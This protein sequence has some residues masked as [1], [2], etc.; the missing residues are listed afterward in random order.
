LAHPDPASEPTLDGSQIW[1]V[2]L[3]R[4]RLIAAIVLA[5]LLLA[6]IQ[7]VA[8]AP[9][10]D[11]KSSQAPTSY[12]ST[13]SYMAVTTSVEGISTEEAVRVGQSLAPT[14][15]TLMRGPSVMT[16]LTAMTG[17]EI[18]SAA[19]SFSITVPPDTALIWVTSSAPDERTAIALAN[20]MASAMATLPGLGEINVG[21]VATRLELV[22]AATSATPV[23]APTRSINTFVLFISV[24]MFLGVLTAFVVEWVDGRAN[25]PGQVESETGM[26]AIGRLEH[27]GRKTDP[28]SMF[29]TSDSSDVEAFRQAKARLKAGLPTAGRGRSLMVTSADSG[30]GKTTIVANLADTLTE[31]GSSVIVVSSDL[32]GT[33]SVESYWDHAGGGPGLSEYLT[34]KSLTVDDIIEPTTRSGVSIIQRGATLSAALPMVDSERMAELVKEL[35]NRAD[36][37]LF[38]A[39]ATSQVSDAQRLAARVDGTLLIVDGVHSTLS[40]VKTAAGQLVDAGGN[41]VG[42]FHNRYRGNPVSSL[43]R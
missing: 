25:W 6:I 16:A 39:P 5:G 32:R 23:I 20:G 2:L 35:T 26:V 8:T 19:Q 38:D 18:P 1:G 15:G 10:S 42:F 27:R 33:A 9:E 7:Q 36:W 41:L 37:T 40:S 4:W 14:Y 30:E 13:A 34:D 22:E 28:V 31:D 3:L 21:P 43:L 11:A 29:V 17:Y 24:A 12:S